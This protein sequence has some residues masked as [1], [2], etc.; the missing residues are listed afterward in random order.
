MVEINPA[1]HL[2]FKSLNEYLLS[3]FRARIV[4]VQIEECS[5]GGLG[6]ILIRYEEEYRV[7]VSF[8]DKAG[9]VIWSAPQEEVSHG[10]ET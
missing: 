5:D 3:R 8:L 4:E 2:I 10:R 1:T 6:M 9:K 7:G